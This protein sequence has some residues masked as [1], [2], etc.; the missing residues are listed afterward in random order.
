LYV[1]DSLSHIPIVTLLSPSSLN[2]REGAR[3]LKQIINIIATFV[4]LGHKLKSCKREDLGGITGKLV[5][6]HCWNAYC[7]SN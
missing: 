5:C 7:F 1:T 3:D 4:E 6:M 2:P